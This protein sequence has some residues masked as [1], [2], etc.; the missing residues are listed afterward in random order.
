MPVL[1][2]HHHYFLQGH[3]PGLHLLMV[4]GLIAAK[5]VNLSQGLMAEGLGLT[6]SHPPHSEQLLLDS[7]PMCPSLP[8]QVAHLECMTVG[9]WLPGTGQ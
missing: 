9:E 8:A 3:P 4:K 7:V 6:E 1:P 2:Y 5:A